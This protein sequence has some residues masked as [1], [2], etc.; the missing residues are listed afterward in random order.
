VIGDGV[1]EVWADPSLDAPQPPAGGEARAL[2]IDS[3]DQ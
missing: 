1:V 2:S 3:A